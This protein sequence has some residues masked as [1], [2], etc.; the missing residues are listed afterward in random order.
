MVAG[1]KYSSQSGMF[2]MHLQPDSSALWTLWIPFVLLST[3]IP[4][5]QTQ[6]EDIILDLQDPDDYVDQVLATLE[7]EQADRERQQ[8]EAA[9]RCRV[10]CLTERQVSDNIVEQ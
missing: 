4:R 5:I 6:I 9:A 2:R 10:R 3:H 8:V 1:S 7:Q